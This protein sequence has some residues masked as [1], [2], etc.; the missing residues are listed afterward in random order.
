MVSVIILQLLRDPYLSSD[1]PMSAP[2]IIRW[3]SMK[4]R[5]GESRAKAL[6]M[7]FMRA[8]IEI[9]LDRAGDEFWPTEHGL[10]YSHELYVEADYPRLSCPEY[11]DEQPSVTYRTQRE[12]AR[13]NKG[14]KGF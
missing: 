12:R 9:P 1:F 8:G 5:A 7:N 13:N 14:P 2:A 3:L 11:G 6:L 4:Y 10:L